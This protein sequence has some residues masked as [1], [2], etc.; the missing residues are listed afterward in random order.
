MKKT[1]LQLFIDEIRDM[2]E[3]EGQHDL[4]PAH[5]HAEKLL[6]TEKQQR[7]D[8]QIELLNEL[9]EESRYAGFVS[10]AEIQKKI[11]ELKKQQP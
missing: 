2:I 5:N 11:R 1:A 4:I 9:M 3:N 7:I 8:I 10:N 6:D